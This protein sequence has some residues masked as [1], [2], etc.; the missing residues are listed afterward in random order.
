MK[1]LYFISL[2][3]KILYV[4]AAIFLLALCSGTEVCAQTH[5]TPTLTNSSTSCYISNITTTG[6]ITN[7]N[8]SSSGFG[9]SYS[10]YYSTVNM[11]ALAG[12]TVNFTLTVAGGSQQGYAV[13]V[14]WNDDGDFSDTGEKVAGSSST[15]ASPISGSFT[16]P[17][18]AAL[19][20]H[21]MRVVVD[22]NTA[23]PSDP[24]QAARGEFEDY[25]LRVNAPGGVTGSVN[26]QNG[27]RTLAC[28]E[29]VNFYD[30]GSSTGNYS[31]NEAYT[32]TFVAANSGVLTV[33]FDDFG[34]ENYNYDFDYLVLYDGNASGRQIAKLGG[35][36]STITGDITT[37]M[38]FTATTGTLTAVWHSDNST[39]KRG[40][41][42]TVTNTCSI[43]YISELSCDNTVTGSITSS[44]VSSECL[45]TNGESRFPNGNLY[46]YQ[47]DSHGVYVV[48][49]QTTSGNPDCF[50]WE[51]GNTNA[52]LGSLTGGSTGSETL[53]VSASVGSRLNIYV[54]NANNGAS[55]YRLWI[56]CP[57]NS[58]DV[59]MTDGS[60]TLACGE[61]VSFFDSGNID[62]NYSDNEDYTYTFT[63]A[64]GGTIVINFPSFLTEN[65]DKLYL[66]DG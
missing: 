51:E 65:L 5:C 18:S 52:C 29:A 57:D 62:A 11:T 53:S 13:W 15:Q 33:S 22:R 46:S 37:P 8:N 38:T 40:W 41:Q 30:S 61:S 17:A 36:N 64:S 59:L 12:T 45:F 7:L 4:A 50:V 1:N 49:F 54:A 24:C 26:M 2:K 60:K 56:E 21:R 43:S 47:I 6:A 16:I 10:D 63:A 19:G 35:S 14:D 58:S 25:A 28:G 55:G 20:T 48:H 34:V 39:N 42:A 44:G 3:A 31:S 66:Y 9:A 23:A 27:S 32:Y